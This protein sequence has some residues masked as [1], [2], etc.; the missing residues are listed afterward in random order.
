MLRL[1]SRTLPHNRAPS[2]T[3][4]HTFLA[5]HDFAIALAKAGH[6]MGQ[7]IE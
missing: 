4:D 7:A 6:S 2:P 1:A 5:C 3:F